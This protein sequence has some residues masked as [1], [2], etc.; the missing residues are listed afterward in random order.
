MFSGLLNADA[1]SGHMKF[2]HYVNLSL[3][4]TAPLAFALSP[5]PLC[6]PLDLVFAVAFPVHAHIGMNCVI[7]DYGQ[8]FFGKG[9]V[10]PMRYGML[11][12][13]AVT[14]LGLLRLTFQ[15]PGL[16][17]TI[18]GLWRSPKEKK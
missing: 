2:Y 17:E 11:G 15:G 18:K 4:G 5:S 3:L 9:A 12:V 16:T 1:T 10:Q 13:T 8:K 6:F 14:T 7:T